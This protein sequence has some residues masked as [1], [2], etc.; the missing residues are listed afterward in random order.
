[1]PAQAGLSSAQGARAV[2]EVG[3]VF[4]GIDAAKS[5]H[6]VAIAEPGRNGEV[7]YLGEIDASTEA[8]RKLLMRLAAKPG[9]LHVCYG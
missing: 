2:T 6:A 7:R 8:V 3:A 5:K 9:K 4:V 1:L